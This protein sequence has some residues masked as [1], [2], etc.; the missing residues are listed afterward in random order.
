MHPLPDFLARVRQ[1]ATPDDTLMVM[2]RSGGRA[3][4]AI[5]LLA[6][7]GFKN[8]YNIVDGMEGDAVQG[9]GQSSS[10]GDG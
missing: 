9:P 4:M 8:V 7:A 1:V 6:Q 5:N 10:T 3:A 2:C